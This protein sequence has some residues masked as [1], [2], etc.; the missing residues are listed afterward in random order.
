[1]KTTT[2]TTTTTT[3]TH[4]SSQAEPPFFILRIF[5]A[6][7]HLSVRFIC[8]TCLRLAGNR[9]RCG[10]T[11]APAQGLDVRIYDA[12]SENPCSVIGFAHGLSTGFAPWR[13]FFLYVLFDPRSPGNVGYPTGAS[14]VGASPASSVLRY[15]I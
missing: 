12:I 10:S 5:T 13:C 6:S 1:M 3:Y 9:R 11:P 15:G 7:D 4:H 14:I 2:T 8:R